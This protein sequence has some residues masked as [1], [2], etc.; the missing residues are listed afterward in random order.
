MNCC[1]NPRTLS[2]LDRSCTS[3]VPKCCDLARDASF[4]VVGTDEGYVLIFSTLDCG[5]QLV[6]AI[7]AH[8]DSVRGVALTDDSLWIASVSEDSRYF[9]RHLDG[10]L[11]VGTSAYQQRMRGQHG[12]APPFACRPLRMLIV[13]R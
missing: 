3:Q 5:P 4:A 8:E 12:T 11:C 10:N 2:D 6:H 7:A 9:P 13:Q 1:A